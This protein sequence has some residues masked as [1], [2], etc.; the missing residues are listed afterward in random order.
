MRQVMQTAWAIYRRHRARGTQLGHLALLRLAL[1]TAWDQAR[2]N[3]R[4]TKVVAEARSEA[5]AVAANRDAASIRAELRDLNY[6]PRYAH[7][8]A[9]LKL[10][11]QFTD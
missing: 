10:A 2:Q 11:L 5:Q 9:T 8:I 7:R 6:A 1:R 4:V 3:A